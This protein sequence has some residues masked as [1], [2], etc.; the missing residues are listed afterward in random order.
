MEFE[1]RMSIPT[2]EGV[3]IDVTL[4]GVGSRAVAAI[5]DGL[6][7]GAILLALGFVMTIVLRDA[8]LV[9]RGTTDTATLA[10]IIAALINVFIFLVLFFYY[11]FFEALWSGRTPGKQAA[12]L[13]VVDLAGRPPGFKVSA[14]RN[15]LRLVD[16]LPISYVVG[17]IAILASSRNQRVGDIVAGTLVVR[18]HSRRKA[19]PRPPSAPLLDESIA[20]WD[21]SDVSREEVN[22]VRAFLDRRGSLT[23]EARIDLAERFA[24]GLRNRVVGGEGE[25]DQE[26]FLERL[27]AAKAERE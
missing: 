12:G 25:P 26:R 19:A 10:L 24:R 18:D 6:I 3:T 17:I 21:V 7:Q 27:V 22:A 16:F 15:L 1:D 20:D 14:I 11:V 4:A 5:V 23:E 2:P 9:D 13:R 8:D